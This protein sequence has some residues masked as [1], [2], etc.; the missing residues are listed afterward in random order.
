MATIRNNSNRAKFLLIGKIL[1]LTSDHIPIADCKRKLAI[2]QYST[3]TEHFNISNLYSA[4]TYINNLVTN[5]YQLNICLLPVP[6]PT[7]QVEGR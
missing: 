7:A 5:V 1:V 3:C 2:A 4:P 6:G